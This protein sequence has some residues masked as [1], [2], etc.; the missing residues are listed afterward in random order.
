MEWQSHY[1]HAVYAWDK[2]KSVGSSILS[3][4]QAGKSVGSSII[5]LGRA[6]WSGVVDWAQHFFGGLWNRIKKIFTTGTDRLKTAGLNMRK[7][8]GEGILSGSEYP[9][10]AA[11]GVAKKLGG[12]LHFHSPPEVGPLRKP[13]LNFRFGE[14]LARHFH[15]APIAIAAERMATVAAAPTISISEHGATVASFGAGERAGG[16]IVIHYSPSI[17]VNGARGSPAD[18]W[19]KAARQHAHELIHIID[20]QLA[21]R[22]RLEFA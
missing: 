15:A 20:Q 6:A 19:V 22:R 3:F 9:F 13:A 21:R 2:I 16:G 10:K 12:L 1:V 7:S 14:E 17:T 8:F 18:D 5:G 11:W 4:G